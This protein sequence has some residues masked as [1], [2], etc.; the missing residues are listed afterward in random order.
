MTRS[1]VEFCWK[2]GGRLSSNTKCCI[3]SP[4]QH[5]TLHS[6]KMATNIM[7]QA[8]SSTLISRNTYSTTDIAMPKKKKSHF[9]DNGF[10]K[11]NKTIKKIWP[12]HPSP[13]KKKSFNSK[14]KVSRVYIQDKIP[15]RLYCFI[16][17]MHIVQR[18]N[19]CL[20]PWFLQYVQICTVRLVGIYPHSSD[21]KPPIQACDS[22]ASLTSTLTGDVP[23]PWD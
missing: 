18:D 10:L 7:F 14:S 8:W 21:I 17:C 15:I 11:T 9:V 22:P 4:W 5:V 16:H 6:N 3:V 13:S 19:P 2:E 12:P 1:G 20:I 23:D